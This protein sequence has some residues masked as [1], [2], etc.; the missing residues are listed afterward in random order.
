VI[1][2]IFSP[3]S[4]ELVKATSLL[5]NFVFIKKIQQCIL[6]SMQNNHTATNIPVPSRSRLPA[7]KLKATFSWDYVFQVHQGVIL[8]WQRLSVHPGSILQPTS[9]AHFAHSNL[10]LLPRSSLPHS[11]S[12]CCI[13]F[14]LFYSILFLNTQVRL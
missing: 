8:A 1:I 2:F 7:G 14:L 3:S 13:V 5:F 9:R 4:P 12:L 11:L 6:I 10:G